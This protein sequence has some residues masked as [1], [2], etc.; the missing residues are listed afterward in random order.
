MNRAKR[1][2]G[3]IGSLLILA[4]IGFNGQALADTPKIGVIDMK[5]VLSASISGQK[6][7]GVI[8]EKMKSLQ[9]PLKKDEDELIALQKEMEKKGSAWT[10]AV[11]QEKAKAFQKKRNEFAAKQD[12]ANNELKK[13]RE[14]NVNP[15]LK[16]LEEIVEKVAKSE[17]YTLILPRNVVLYTSDATDISDK[18]TSELNKVMK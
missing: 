2:I 7:Q 12:S 1:T 17:G 14:D 15:I 6:A 9:S 4:V 5:K 3:C 13:L 10:D 8:E 16:K 18:I 11:K